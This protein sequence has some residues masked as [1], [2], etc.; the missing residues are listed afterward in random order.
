MCNRVVINWNINAS[1]WTYDVYQ[2]PKAYTRK[3]N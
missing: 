1:Q 3:W 2:V